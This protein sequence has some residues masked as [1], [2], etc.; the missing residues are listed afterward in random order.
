MKKKSLTKNAI[1]NGIRAVLNILFPLITFPYISRTLGVDYYGKYQF[2]N[3]IVNYFVL[4]AALG[5]SSYAI[6]EGSQYKS[7]RKKM[8][9]FAS[10]VFSINLFSTFI[11][12]GA[13][14]ATIFFIP[15]LH[16]YRA[17]LFIL[18]F[19][20]IFNTIGMDWL[21]SIYEEFKYITIRTIIFQIIS[22]ILMFLFVHTPND[23]PFYVFIVVLSSSGANILNYFKTRKNLKIH[24][25]PHMNLKKHITPILILFFSVL[26]QQ[27]YINSDITLLGIMNGDDAV[28]LYSAAAKIYTIAKQLVNAIIAVSI[29]RIS[30]YIGS[31]QK[32]SAE[33]MNK[34]LNVVMVFILPISMGLF[35]ISK[36]VVLIAAGKEYL[37]AYQPLAILS[38]S[39]LFATCAYF[40]ANA[41][42]VNYKKEKI[43]LIVSIISSA[44][45]I[46]LNFALLPVLG[47][48]GAAI[49]TLLSEILMCIICWLK[50]KQIVPFHL[51]FKN[52]I[53]SIVGC[54]W[55]VVICGL[56]TYLIPQ[57][58]L[59]TFVAIVL[60]IGGYFCIHLLLK[61]N[62]YL[63]IIQPKIDMFLKKNARKRESL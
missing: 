6:R 54:L 26:S 49:T 11:A 1:M 19:T 31:K 28:G 2:S 36:P 38:I 9:Q 23:L 62:F 18:S 55:I 10:E 13:L 12:F 58:Y 50:A 57:L 5:I 52:V 30:Y 35:M 25:T 53:C 56:S 59:K 8:S 29:P 48:C 46:L 44:M 40:F 41:I 14:M 21:L 39:L 43:V 34:V 42:L 63:E 37:C 4:L 27:I 32:D 47:I 20:I 3:S 17:L 24:F 15:G 45:N 60:S 61:S 22:I 16:E 51:E 7:D 33:F